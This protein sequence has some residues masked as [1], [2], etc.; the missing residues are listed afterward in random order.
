MRTILILLLFTSLLFSQGFK[1]TLKGGVDFA[2]EHSV[3]TK[4]ELGVIDE[5]VENSFSGAIEATH[6]VGDIFDLGV[7]TAYFPSRNGKQIS[8]LE[9]SLLPIYSIIK[10]NVLTLESVNPQII[11]HIGYTTFSTGEEYRNNRDAQGGTYIAMGFGLNPYSHFYTEI[12][13]NAF[14]FYY[15]IPGGNEKTESKIQ[16]TNISFYIGWSF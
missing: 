2:A 1:L 5:R 15:N 16:F 12:L 6:T 4:Y 14:N 11:S 7:G 9:L 13:F 3:D 10:I 8:N